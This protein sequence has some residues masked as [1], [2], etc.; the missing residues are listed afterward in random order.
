MAL[1]LPLQAFGGLI[2]LAVQGGADHG[3]GLPGI[4]I[5]TD[6]GMG[7]APVRLAGP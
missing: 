6:V 3:D 5:G 4:G 2:V 7:L 1:Y